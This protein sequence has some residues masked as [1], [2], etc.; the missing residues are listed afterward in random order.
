METVRKKS[1]VFMAMFLM[2]AALLLSVVQQVRADAPVPARNA[3]ETLDALQAPGS[4]AVMF[5]VRAVD[6]HNGLCLP[7]AACAGSLDTTPPAGTPAW[8]VDGVIKLPISIPFWI[9]TNWPNGKTPSVNRR[10]PQDPAEVKTIIETLLAAGVID[11]NTQIHVLCRTAVRS[12]LMVHWILDQGPTGFYN[13]K[14]DTYGNFNSIFDIDSDGI[15]GSTNNVPETYGGMKLWNYVGNPIYTTLAGGTYPVPPQ[16]FSIAPADGDTTTNADVTFTVGILEATPSPSFSYSAVTDV[17]LLI[18]GSIADSSAVDTTGDIWS[19]YSFQQTLDSGSYVWDSSAANSSGTSWNPHALASGLGGRTLNVDLPVDCIDNDG[20]G[21]GSPGDPACPNGAELDC[22]DTDSSVNPGASDFI[23]DGVD[24]NC[25]GIS[26]DEYLPTDTVCGLG[27]CASTGLL[28]CINGSEVDSCTAGTPGDDS[29]CDGIDDDCD[30]VADNNYV[31]IDT[32]CG[33]GA[34]ASTGQKICDNGQT[35][36]TCVE[37]T[38]GTEGPAGDATCSDSVDNDCD[39]STDA[40]DT[41]C[42]AGCIPTGDD[43]NCDG[44]DDDCD[45][46]ADNNYVPI[47]TTCGVGACASTG[48]KICDNGQRI[49]TC[50]EGTP[51]TEGPA[52]DATCSDSVDNDCDGST[53]AVDPDCGKITSYT[54]RATASW[55]G[56]ISPSGDVVVDAGSDQTFTIKPWKHGHF[57]IKDVLVDGV[58]VGPVATYTFQNVSSD[59]TIHAEFT[60]KH[61]KYKR[62]KKHHRRKYIKSEDS[63]ED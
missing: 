45:G 39:G 60:K 12:H 35:T 41:D 27:A 33:V 9:D 36:D 22:D 18:D 58:S 47:D 4:T 1:S 10:K 55:G 31:P 37:G 21:Y 19:I 59:H 52:G 28:E 53:D 25:N 2:V 48:Q 50:V 51:G 32:T 13:A 57:K 34:C 38:P 40:D 54:I 8:T 23:C 42:V 6:E 5:D 15:E 24:N 61:R 20:D 43:S 16:V 11:F 44:I 30:G 3:A 7:W 56:K 26:D 14:T 62:H 46:V 63:E 49:D 17:S 29:N